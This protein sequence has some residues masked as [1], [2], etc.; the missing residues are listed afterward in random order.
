MARSEVYRSDGKLCERIENCGIVQGIVK[1]MVGCVEELN[2]GRDGKLWQIT[3]NF[4]R[5]GIV[6]ENG[7][8]WD[9]M[10]N[11]GVQQEFVGKS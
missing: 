11:L 5:E 4:R 1:D 9:R 3:E 8:L 2:C 6:G 10:N 7:G